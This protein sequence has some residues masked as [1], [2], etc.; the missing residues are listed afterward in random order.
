MSVERRALVSSVRLCDLSLERRIALASFL[1][2]L[3]AFY[4]LAQVKL[5]HAV[6]G[7]DSIPGAGRVLARYHGDPARSRLHH[8][9]DPTLSANDPTRMF[10]ALGSREEERSA[11]RGKILA[12]VERG[13]PRDE[14]HTVST[15]F[16]GE[17]T[18]GACHS[19]RQDGDRQRLKAD[20]P[21]ESF[22]QVVK[23]ARPG[24]G[25]SVHELATSSHN[26]LI[27]FAIVALMTSWAFTLTRWRGPLVRT[28]VLLSFGGAA[29]DVSCWWLTRA[30]GHPYEYGVILGG[31]AFGAAVLAMALLSLDELVLDGRTGRFIAPLARALHLGE[32]VSPR[33]AATRSS[34]SIEATVKGDARGDAEV[35]P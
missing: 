8:V 20:V 18:C 11:R 21:F 1:G 22:E 16:T 25:M 23:F 29:V 33:L 15:I 9:L 35:R 32:P 30:F 3:L 19:A 17:S 24:T 26:H 10:D 4:G 13:A 14:W 6:G 31:G 34:G 27:G 2:L 12:W 5:V 7:G 28:L